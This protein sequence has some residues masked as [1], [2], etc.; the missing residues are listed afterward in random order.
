VQRIAVARRSR[1]NRQE[2]VRRHAVEQGVRARGHEVILVFA[3]KIPYMVAASGPG[4]CETIKSN[5]SWRRLGFGDVLIID[6]GST[7]D[8]YFC[9]FD[10][11]FA[12]GHVADA[13]RRA[14]DLVDAATDLGIHAARGGC[15]ASDVWRTMAAQVCEKAVRGLAW[16]G[17]GM[18]WAWP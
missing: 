16:D 12:F 13:A 14:H 6:T 18:A 5:P 9:D 10:R 17:W 15:T 8:G 11:N 2:G 7:V 1:G 3:P 4:G